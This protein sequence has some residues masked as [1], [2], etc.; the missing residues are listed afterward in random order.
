MYAAA[1]L[2][3]HLERPWSAHP[4]ADLIILLPSPRPRAH[5]THRSPRTADLVRVMAVAQAHVLGCHIL[6]RLVFPCLQPLRCWEEQ[7]TDEG[8]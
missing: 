5:I 4:G 8:R 2:Q 3:C 1:G 7:Q 6:G